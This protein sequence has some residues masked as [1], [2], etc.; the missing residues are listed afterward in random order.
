VQYLDMTLLKRSFM[1]T[2]LGP[3]PTKK[4][5]QDCISWV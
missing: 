3:A 4:P 1:K 5:G 2:S